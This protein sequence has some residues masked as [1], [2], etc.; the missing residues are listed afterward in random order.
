MFSRLRG[1]H[2]FVTI[3]TVSAIANA[4]DLKEARVTKIIRDV[5]LLPNAAPARPAAVD[6]EVRNGTAGRTGIESRTELKFT[7]ETLARLGANTIFS[8]NE[9]TRNLELTDGAM[10]LR[11]PKNAGG[12]KI[13]TA[14]VT[15]AITGTT[16]MLEFHKN[17]YVKFI[18]LEGT[19]RIFLP[20]R[21]GES[22]LIRA[23]QMLITK[24]DA[25]NLSNPVDVDIRQLRK[26]SRLIKGFGKMG[27]ENLIAQTEAGQDKERAQGELYET[28]LAIYGAG[29]SILLTD[30]V[31][32]QETQ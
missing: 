26:T 29:T 10:L 17:S 31:H 32:I 24:P 18:V 21:V 20:N 9:G 13:N 22:V 1:C 25:K 6:D 12:A 23:G 30:Q 27:S 8:F 4:A 19:G 2:L 28:N 7:D 5:K 14:A 15:A 3:L 16:V 11:V